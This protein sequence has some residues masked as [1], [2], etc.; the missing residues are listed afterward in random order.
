MCALGSCYGFRMRE[1]RRKGG[2]DPFR[3]LEYLHEPDYAR[4]L[5]GL[6]PEL[7]ARARKRLGF[8]YGEEAA[9]PVLGHV[10]RLVRV[11]DAH[12]TP[13]IRAAEEAFDPRERFT[14]KDAVLITY[15]DLVVSEGRSPLATL[16][17]F[18]YVLFRGLVT[19]VHVLPFFPSSS[20][21]GFSII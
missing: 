8:L 11:H 3:G 10:D 15:G 2:A 20:D 1:S 18:A 9:E 17:D 16:S 4:P 12:A 19:T 14:E 5:R 7:A 21:R 13:E 6:T